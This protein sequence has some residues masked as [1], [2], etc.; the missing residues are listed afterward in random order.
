MFRTPTEQLQSL[1]GRL[2]ARR[3]ALGWTQVEA[4][5]RAGVA[6]RTWRRLENEGQA[7]LEDMVR[8]AVAL[9]CDE[10]LEALF[11]LPVAAS[12][13]ELL[14]RQA[15]TARRPSRTRAP[16]TRTGKS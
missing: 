5:Q 3:V 10:G 13:D 4:A 9:R 1:A 16:R 6:Y 11:P 14:A 15:A 12:L 7:S 2:K 8:A